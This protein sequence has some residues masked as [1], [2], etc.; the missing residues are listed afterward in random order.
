MSS[1]VDGGGGGSSRDVG[2]P[3]S[4]GSGDEVCG[5]CGTAD[6]SPWRSLPASSAMP[7]AVIGGFNWTQ[8]AHRHHVSKGR[9]FESGYLTMNS[10]RC[11]FERMVLK[12]IDESYRRRVFSVRNWFLNLR[13]GY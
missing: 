8:P 1:V 12:G 4:A 7:S 3:T 5:S 10:V 13:F 9:R 2:E 11:E 6:G